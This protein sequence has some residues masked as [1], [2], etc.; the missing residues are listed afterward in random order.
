MTI[1]E[2]QCCGLGGCAG[3]KEPELAEKMVSN[4]SEK[5]KVY[6]YCASCFGNF[7]RK[8]YEGTEHIPT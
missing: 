3:R 2:G 5:D 8:G 7:F 6:T 4:I 1:L